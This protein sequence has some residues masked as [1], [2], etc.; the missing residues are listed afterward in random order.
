MKQMKE[1]EYYMNIMSLKNIFRE[2]RIEHSVYFLKLLQG[3]F[4]VGNIDIIEYI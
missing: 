3:S 2:D 4:L 1:K